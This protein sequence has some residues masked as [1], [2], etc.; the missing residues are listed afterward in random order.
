LER[1][2]PSCATISLA[3]GAAEWVKGEMKLCAQY[4]AAVLIQ[5]SHLRGRSEDHARERLYG[6]SLSYMDFELVLHRPIET[7]RIIGHRAGLVLCLQTLLAIQRLRALM[8]SEKTPVVRAPPF[9]PE[10]F[11]PLPGSLPRVGTRSA[12]HSCLPVFSSG[13]ESLNDPRRTSLLPEP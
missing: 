2:S 7:T 8:R 3:P 6:F 5:Q 4:A 13:H 1:A 12:L 10:L 11:W 9:L